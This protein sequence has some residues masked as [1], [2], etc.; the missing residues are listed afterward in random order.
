ME[1]RSEFGVTVVL[2]NKLIIPTTASSLVLTTNDNEWHT[3]EIPI[4]VYNTPLGLKLDY[5]QGVCRLL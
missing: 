3:D 5:S 1:T 4:Q 2:Y